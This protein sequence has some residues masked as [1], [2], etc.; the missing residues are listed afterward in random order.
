MACLSA[1]GPALAQSS[2]PLFAP[3]GQ[4]PLTPGQRDLDFEHNRL[5]RAQQ[6][7]QIDRALS[8]PPGSTIEAP[9]TTP[10]PDLTRPGHTVAVSGV[11][12][13]FGTQPVLFDAQTLAREFLHRP[14]DNQGLFNLVRLL[15]ARLY[16]LGYVT[17]N[18]ALL[19]PALKNGRLQLKVNWGRIKGWRINGKPLQTLRDR[20]MV[21]WAIPNWWRS[22]L[23]IR[24]LDQAIENM[25]NG[26]KQVTVT[27]APAEEYGY[28]Y[29]DLRVERAAWARFSIGADNSGLG[30]PQQGRDKYSLSVG[31]GDL[32]G[33]SDSLNLFASRRYFSD[34]GSDGEQSYDLSYRIPLGYTRIDLQAGYSSYKNLLRAHR[35]A[36]QSAGNSRNV[37]LRITRTV[38]R[39]ATSQFS[40]YGALKSRQ[41]KNYL[42]QTRLD[43]SSKHYSDGT[44]GLQ[45]SVQRGRQAMFADLS[46]NRGLGLNNGQYSAFDAVNARG[47]ASRV[48]A[49]VS[50][51]G[52]FAPG[53]QALRVQSQLGFQYSR[54]ILLNSYQLTLGDEYTVHGFSRMTSQSGDKGVYWSNTVSLPVRWPR[55]AGVSLTPFAGLDVGRLQ[56]NQ[57]TAAVS[58]AGWALGVRLSSPYW[59][60]SATY[61]RAMWSPLPKKP[62][63]YLSTSFVF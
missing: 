8:Q 34:A 54:Q 14:L 5:Q 44:L 10:A 36:Y 49:I 42:A 24:D 59:N 55:L 17:S 6:Q 22:P 20:A 11:D 61:A 32:L 50:W 25:N 30:T 2:H 3:N 48:N 29:L 63:W 43:V 51:Q 47:Y 57:D 56:N 35:L 38:Y 62:L 28:S 33:I 7:R 41:N 58:M 40:L 4:Q 23:N 16:E 53:G 13:D 39:D 52:S 31:T 15:T 18:I 9:E 21:G 12:L 60:L 26:L 27:I 19:E 37:S 45:W 46:W 1:A